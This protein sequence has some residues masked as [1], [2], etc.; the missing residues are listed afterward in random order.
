MRSKTGILLAA[1]L[2]A[3]SVTACG[4]GEGVLINGT[5]AAQENGTG[6]IPDTSSETGESLEPA[7]ETVPEPTDEGAQGPARIEIVTGESS[8]AQSLESQTEPETT[9][10]PSTEAAAVTA[11]TTAAATTA[12]QTTAAKVYTVR[13]VDKTMY[14][15]SAVRVRTG[16]STSTE[17][18]GALE[19]GESVKCTGES[20]NGWMRVI[21]NGKEGFVSKSY[22]S[23]TPT[24]TETSSGNNTASGGT[25]S[26]T[27]TTP[28]GTTP[29]TTTTP[30]GTTPGTTTTP[31]GTTPGT[32]T[33]PGGNNGPTSVNPGATTPGG[34]TSPGT[35]SG[36]NTG[37]ASG[38]TGSVTGTITSLDPSGVTIQTS[39][40]ASYSFGWGSSASALVAEGEQVQLYYNGNTVVQIVK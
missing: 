6:E 23:D 35:P 38:A 5:T 8:A 31:G 18:L 17:I 37:N 12:P 20:D 22:L 36:Q 1:V 28:G 16:Y 7:E 26:G 25:T 40:G 29:G 2:A 11:T 14:A 32:T 21:W 24:K 13:D 3:L 30:G 9:Q 4:N 39:S 33:T 19:A 15:K 27:T 10:P 34:T